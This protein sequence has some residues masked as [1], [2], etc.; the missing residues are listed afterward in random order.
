M[1]SPAVAATDHTPPTPLLALAAFTRR[2]S[3]DPAREPDV[4]AVPTASG[5]ITLHA[6]LGLGL[7]TP[8]RGD[9]R[10]GRA[11]C[12]RPADRAAYRAHPGMRRSR[13]RAAVRGQLTSRPAPLVLGGGLWQS[14]PHQGVSTAT[15]GTG[16]SY[17][18]LPAEQAFWRPSNQV[19][20]LGQAAASPD[21]R[22]AAV[23]PA[24]GSG[25]NPPPALIND[26]AVPASRGHGTDSSR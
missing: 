5:W 2:G 17:R 22:R 9:V 19:G 14:H 1:R 18:V 13:L 8:G 4:V 15:K 26:R 23:A 6:S 10:R 16:M 12:A 25:I 7:P 24:S 11:R 20:V 21:A 3:D